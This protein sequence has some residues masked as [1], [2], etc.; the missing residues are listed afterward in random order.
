MHMEPLRLVYE[1][2]RLSEV[3]YGS[4]RFSRITAD[5]NTLVVPFLPSSWS[6]IMYDRVAVHGLCNCSMLLLLRKML[7]MSPLYGVLLCTVANPFHLG[8]LESLTGLVHGS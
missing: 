7:K 8:S 3:C 6:I 5:Y 2:S 4:K 1:G